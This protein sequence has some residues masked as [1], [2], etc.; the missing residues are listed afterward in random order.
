MSEDEYIKE[1]WDRA[2]LEGD[3]KYRQLNGEANDP[4]GELADFTAQQKR[5]QEIMLKRAKEELR[6]ALD[7]ENLGGDN[8]PGLD[9]E[10]AP[11]NP[12]DKKMY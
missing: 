8:I 9:D 4:E 6:S 7:E 10:D 3:I 2:L 12:D 11:E 5:K 1:V